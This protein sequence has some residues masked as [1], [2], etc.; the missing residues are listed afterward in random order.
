V[1]EV[2]GADEADDLDREIE[3]LLEE[4]AAREHNP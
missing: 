3:R 4:L 1:H 2:K